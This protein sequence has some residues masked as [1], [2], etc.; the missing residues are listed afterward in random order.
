MKLCWCPSHSIRFLFFIHELIKL[1]PSHA[2]LLSRKALPQGWRPALIHRV[3]GE[4]GSGL[5]SPAGGLPPGQDGC[6]LSSPH[7]QPLSCKGASEPAPPRQSPGLCPGAWS[8]PWVSRP[9]I[10]FSW[11]TPQCLSSTSNFTCPTQIPCLTHVLPH[12]PHICSSFTIHQLLN[13]NEGHHWTP[14]PIRVAC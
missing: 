14:C 11:K 2:A 7:T 5:G 12:S 3:P 10:W 6:R 1:F 9:S 4:G 8:P 13:P